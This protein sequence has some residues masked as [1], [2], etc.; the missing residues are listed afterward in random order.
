MSSNLRTKS[1][2]AYGI[3]GSLVGYKV[4]D[5]TATTQLYNWMM[6]SP[7]DILCQK[8][9]ICILTDQQFID[10]FSIWKNRYSFPLV[11]YLSELDLDGLTSIHNYT[12]G[13][14]VDV[15]MQEQG[16]FLKHLETGAYHYCDA[17]GL[18]HPLVAEQ[19]SGNHGQFAFQI[20][21]KNYLVAYV[22]HLFNIY[23]VLQS[24][25]DSDSL[26]S[27]L[28]YIQGHTHD[29]SAQYSN[30]RDGNS[31]IET[32]F[33][34]YG[35]D[36]CK[37]RIRYILKT[38]P[39]YLSQVQ[40]LLNE[41]DPFSIVRTFGNNKLPIH[42]CYS[43]VKIQTVSVEQVHDIHICNQLDSGSVTI[44][45]HP[46][47]NWREVS[48][49]GETDVAY[50]LSEQLARQMGYSNLEMQDGSYVAAAGEETTTFT[51]IKDYFGNVRIMVETVKN[52]CVPGEH[53]N[54]P[55]YSFIKN[56]VNY[57]LTQEWI[58]HHQINQVTE[59]IKEKIMI[60]AI[61]KPD[62]FPTISNEEP[63]SCRYIFKQTDGACT[64][65]TL[66]IHAF[67]TVNHRSATLYSGQ[68]VA[69]M[70]DVCSAIKQSDG[71]AEITGYDTFCYLPILI[72]QNI[73]ADFDYTYVLKNESMH[74][75]E[76]IDDI[77]AEIEENVLQSSQSADLQSMTPKRQKRKM[78]FFKGMLALDDKISKKYSK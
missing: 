48:I 66:D 39:M 18:E 75:E 44:T 76:V 16:G 26:R 53:L 47:E 31:T 54:L 17:S 10:I 40:A 78:S 49:F 37:S 29:I 8:F 42:I 56:D 68:V 27:A 55:E 6:D 35:K 23:S 38:Q 34:P 60:W 74:S 14:W 57:Q 73:I 46:P 50:C 9:T 70:T 65:W 72:S 11:E 13:K 19:I 67:K 32:V 71:V 61:R 5:C 41:A 51:W 3:C 7:D 20:Q 24:Q 64:N 30:R 43:T 69:S 52:V 4:A 36:P 33:Q 62:R 45:H 58:K 21:N 2:L 12:V 63:Q 28:S 1:T 22:E 25:L 77:L 59:S 15:T